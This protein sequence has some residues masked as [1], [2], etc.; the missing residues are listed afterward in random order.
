ML[1]R[2]EFDEFLKYSLEAGS[3]INAISNSN[4]TLNHSGPH[5]Q[6]NI[7]MKV[8]EVPLPH[9]KSL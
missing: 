5:E 4:G 7:Y 3:T 2:T 6:W 1:N 8:E 9:D